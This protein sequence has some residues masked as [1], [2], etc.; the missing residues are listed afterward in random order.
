[1]SFTIGHV[2]VDNDHVTIDYDNTHVEFDAGAYR[3][4]MVLPSTNTTIPA[5]IAA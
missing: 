5:T 1:M 2:T 3:R 4:P